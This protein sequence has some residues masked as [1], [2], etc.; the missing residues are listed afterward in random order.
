MSVS[1]TCVWG[2]GMVGGFHVIMISGKVYLIRT[3]DERW[4]VQVRSECRV[5][6]A[7]LGKGLGSERAWSCGA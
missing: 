4:N 3:V 1:G 6:L 2:G 7:R 5:I